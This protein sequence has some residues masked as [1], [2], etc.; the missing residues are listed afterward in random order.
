M[1]QVG[2][3]NNG[4]WI[5]RPLKQ[6][7]SDYH[8]P[9]QEYSQEFKIPQMHESKIELQSNEEGGSQSTVPIVSLT[10]KGGTSSHY[11]K[12]SSRR[13]LFQKKSDA[14][15]NSMRNHMKSIS[16]K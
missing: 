6:M 9:H 3:M 1:M 16:S 4:E 2:T 13:I 5:K 12:P 7:G 15:T 14:T 10:S 11:S 8:Y